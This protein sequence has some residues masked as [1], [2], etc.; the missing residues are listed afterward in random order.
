MQ[1]GIRALGDRVPAA[2]W[3]LGV[4]CACIVAIGMI[5]PRLSESAAGWL[6]LAA[7]LA[8]AGAAAAFLAATR[9]VAARLPLVSGSLRLVD[10]VLVVVRRTGL[11]LLGLAFFLLWTFVYL[12]LWWFR[13]EATFAGLEESP[14][15]ADFFY[16]AVMTALTSPPEDIVAVSRGARSATMIEILTGIALLTT[17]LS[18]LFEARRARRRDPEPP[19]QGLAD[20][21]AA[22][23]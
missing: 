5:R 9:R 19:A 7:G 1:G 2:G 23:P 16:Y 14:R 22:T 12:G 21:P 8:T 13:P 17:Y 20:D 6:L 18:S 11:P 10:A 4:L 3:R 15:F